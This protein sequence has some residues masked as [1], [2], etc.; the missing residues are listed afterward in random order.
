MSGLASASELAPAIIRFW[1]EEVGK[2]RWFARDKVL[3][4]EIKRRFGKTRDV[5]LASRAQG[6]RDTPEHI[7]AAILLLDQCSRNINR[8]SARAFEGDALALE[9]A[10]LALDRG[11]TRSASKDWQQ[12]LLMPLQHSENL[13]DQE[14]SLAE[15]EQLGDEFVLGFA[16]MHFDQVRRFGRFPGRN[17]ALGRVSSPDELEV[18]GRGEIFQQSSRRQTFVDNPKPYI[19]LDV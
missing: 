16:R 1:F 11:W 14:R 13:S 6:W 2:N 8:G 9:L 18:I 12:F 4:A 15:F 19:D 5:V 3:D 7:L 10:T 17:R